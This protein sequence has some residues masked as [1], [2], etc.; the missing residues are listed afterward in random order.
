MPDTRFRF[1]MGHFDTF[2]LSEGHFS[3]IFEG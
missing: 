1:Q 2:W 3:G